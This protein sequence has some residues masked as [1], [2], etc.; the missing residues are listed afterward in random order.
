[1]DLDFDLR[2]DQGLPQSAFDRL[3]E[4]GPV[5]WSEP[6]GGWM[7][8]SYQ[9]VRSVLGDVNRFTMA[10]TP[11][12]ES[13][14][15]EGMLVDDTPFHHT[16]RAIWAPH[17]SRE[18]M[19]ARLD[20]LK[21]YAAQVLEEVRPRL[22]AGETVNLTPVF[23][24]FVMQFIASSFDVPRE[25]LTVFERWSELSADTPALALEEGSD[26]QQRHQA[27][28]KDVVELVR[29]QIE[30]RKQRFASGEDP[31]DLISL[32][33]A[34]ESRDGFS[35]SVVTDNLFNFILGA[36]DT[37][38]KWLGNIVVKLAGSP[39]LADELR[40]DE[41][42]IEAFNEEVMR[43][44]SVAQTVQRRVREGGA[45]LGGRQLNGGDPVFLLLG[46]ANRDGSEFDDPDRFDMHR[47]NK[48]HL[49]FGFGFHH[50]L[51]VNIARQEARAFVSVLLDRFPWLQVAGA[52]YGESWALWGPRALHV[53]LPDRG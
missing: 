24:N 5:V 43:V 29:Q 33:V 35:R 9:A 51:G 22:E 14:G 18:A 50:C 39:D 36:M 53:A 41:S 44:H 15:K 13:L 37:T 4:A 21:G 7:V 3:R 20:E 28:Q 31:Q 17:V 8:S 2:L 47:A 42:L 23:R 12:A 45:E 48:A 46:A 32:M 25:K 52:D 6:L 1:M 10:G 30:D 26:A 38:E 49:G 27:A 40:A 34:A 11:V 16:V 19:M